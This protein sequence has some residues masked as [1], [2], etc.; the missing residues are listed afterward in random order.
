[1]LPCSTMM[2]PGDRP[3]TLKSLRQKHPEA[4]LLLTQLGGCACPCWWGWQGRTE[5]A[6][7][8]RGCAGGEHLPSPGEKTQR[9]LRSPE[10]VPGAVRHGTRA[11]QGL[12]A[13]K[14]SHHCVGVFKMCMK[15][16]PLQLSTRKMISSFLGRK[17]L[18]TKY[19]FVTGKQ[20]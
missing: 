1:M 3:G 2:A 16:A 7:K 17:H 6:R 12:C 11:H 10:S 5:S 19:P 9:V 13:V 4:M 18:T 14:A 8:C 20:L 15:K